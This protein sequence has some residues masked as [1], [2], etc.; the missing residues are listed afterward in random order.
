VTP[1]NERPKFNSYGNI[2]ASVLETAVNADGANGRIDGS[3]YVGPMIIATGEKGQKY[4]SAA[5]TMS[6]R[7]PQAHLI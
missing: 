4:N 2:F 3:D 7:A 5:T 1:Q 6:P